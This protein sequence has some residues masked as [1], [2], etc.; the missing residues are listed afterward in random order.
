[1]SFA[2]KRLAEWTTAVRTHAAGTVD[3]PLKTVASWPPEHVTL[4]LRLVFPQ[5]HRLLESDDVSHAGART[6]D[7]LMLGLSLHTDIAIVERYAWPG[8]PAGRGPSWS[9]AG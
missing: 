5:L 6:V 3:E 9:T 4:V 2:Q 8:D 7:T 1:M